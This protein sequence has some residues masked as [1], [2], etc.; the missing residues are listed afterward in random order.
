MPSVWLLPQGTRSVTRTILS[1]L[2]VH[3]NNPTAEQARCLRKPSLFPGIWQ[4]GGHTGIST[5]EEQSLVTKGSSENASKNSFTLR[6]P[7]ASQ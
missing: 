6:L 5:W 7:R 1:P 4:M 3:T 2:K